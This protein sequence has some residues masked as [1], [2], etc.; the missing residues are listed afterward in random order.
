MPDFFD[1]LK[2]SI[3]KGTAIVGAKSTTLIETNKLKQD[4]STTERLKRDTLMELGKKVYA[5]NRE[6]TFTMDAV[7]ELITKIAEAEAK[8]V[9]LEAK[10]KV[11][12]DEEKEKLDEINAMEAKGTAENPVD[13]QSTEVEPSAEPAAPVPPVGSEVSTEEDIEVEVEEEGSESDN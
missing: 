9:D 8:V 7:E 5:L 3:D 11:L 10:I 6:G 2:K 13:A 12:Q 1:K 4:I